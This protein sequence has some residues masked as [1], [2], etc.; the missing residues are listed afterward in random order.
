M[1]D[2]LGSP[3]FC[4]FKMVVVVI[5]GVLEVF[6]CCNCHCLGC[7]LEITGV[8][9]AFL[10]CNCR[11]FEVFLGNYRSYS[12]FLVSTTAVEISC[13]LEITAPTHKLFH[14]QL[15]FLNFTFNSWQSSS[16]KASYNCCKISR[17]LFK[18]G[19]LNFQ[20]QPL[21]TVNFKK[22]FEMDKILIKFG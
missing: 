16:T 3:V 4:V 22:D 19:S 14:L 17:S 15:P 11:Y 9:G 21:S 6:L 13:I 1:R 2:C 10:C 20:N 7:F 12:H 18:H 5:T 8:V